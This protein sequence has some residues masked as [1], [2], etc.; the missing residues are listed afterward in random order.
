MSYFTIR[1]DGYFGFE[2][3]KSKFIGRA[4]R[5]YSE[6]EA[7][8]FIEEVN[9]LNKDARHNVYAYVIG[10]KWN[11]ERYNDDGEPQGTAGIPMLQTIKKI[12]VTEV[13]VVVTR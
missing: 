13:V 7:K 4:K 8:A 3:K 12:N 11:I 10:E 9:L 5:V 2:E 1:N 6:E